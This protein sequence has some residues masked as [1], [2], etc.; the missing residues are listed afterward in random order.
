LRVEGNKLAKLRLFLTFHST[1][2]TR[3]DSG[4]TIQHEP[5][6]TG[7][8]QAKRGECINISIASSLQTPQA[9]STFQSSTRP[10]LRAKDYLQLLDR[11]LTYTQELYEEA[12]T[13]KSLANLQMPLA[14]SASVEGNGTLSEGL[15][16][17]LRA[18]CALRSSVVSTF[19]S[20]GQP[21][22]FN[23]PHSI[24]PSPA[25]LLALVSV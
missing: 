6:R 8:G 2:S 20:C 13:W 24:C 3:I 16:R 12:N 14:A 21:L 1:S 9:T 18:H 22:S 19:R 4:T 15:L 25:L 11:P 5:Y 17:S 23:L 10:S 7:Y